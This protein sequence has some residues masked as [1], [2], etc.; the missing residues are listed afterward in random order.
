MS[1]IKARHILPVDLLEK[2]QKYV[3]GECIYIPKA[4]YNKQEWGANTSTRKELKIRNKQI[5]DDYLKGQNTDSLSSKYFLS[6]KSVQRIIRQQ[7]ECNNV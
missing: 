4:A 1:Y 7:K 3:D 5:Y 2:V 6:L